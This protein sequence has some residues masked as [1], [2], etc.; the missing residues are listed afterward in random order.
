VREIFAEF[1]VEC[2]EAQGARPFR[3]FS[4]QGRRFGAAR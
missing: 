3:P 2:R 1:G 4:F